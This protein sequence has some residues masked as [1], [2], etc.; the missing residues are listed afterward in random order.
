MDKLTNYLKETRIEMKK[1][2]WPTRQETVRYTI[3]VIA[4]S[5]AVAAVLGAFDFIFSR[6]IRLFI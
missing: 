6:V 2:N 5:L 1:V 3:T 4:V